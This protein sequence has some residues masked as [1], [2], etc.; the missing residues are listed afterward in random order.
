MT[1]FPG[2]GGAGGLGRFAGS[3]WFPNLGPECLEVGAAD[4]VQRADPLGG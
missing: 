4:H 2:A 3:A 1:P